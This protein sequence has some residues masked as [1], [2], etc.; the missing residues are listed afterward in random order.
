MTALPNPFDFTSALVPSTGAEPATT[1]EPSSHSAMVAGNSAC[2]SQEAI[3]PNPC[4]LS[5]GS[6]GMPGKIDQASVFSECEFCGEATGVRCLAESAA[7]CCPDA[8]SISSSCGGGESRPAARISPAGV[9]R[10]TKATIAGAVVKDAS[11][12]ERDRALAV[13]S[14]AGVASSPH[15]PIAETL[16]T[17]SVFPGEDHIP[18]L[19]ALLKERCAPEPFSEYA[20]RRSL[21]IVSPPMPYHAI[22]DRNRFEPDIDAMYDYNVPPEPPLFLRNPRP[23]FLRALFQLGGTSGPLR[24]FSLPHA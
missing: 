7:R 20:R 16:H 10:A 2:T 9:D 11:G 17:P 8:P 3:A 5:T 14:L 21:P 4:D 22:Q 23:A 18:E 13:A 15:D 24:L 1:H 6:L 12:C 19:L